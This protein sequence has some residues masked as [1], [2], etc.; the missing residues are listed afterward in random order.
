M[1]ISRY[2]TITIHFPTLGPS[3]HSFSPKD[4]TQSYVHAH[5]PG[6]TLSVLVRDL[7]LCMYV[8]RVPAT[9]MR[10]ARSRSYPPCRREVD[11]LV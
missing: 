10:E 1:I 2:M 7:S 9:V 11:R 8:V 5:S 3:V 6:S 4:K